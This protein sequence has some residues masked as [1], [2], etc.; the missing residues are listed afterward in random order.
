MRR[1]KGAKFNQIYKTA[2]DKIYSRAPLG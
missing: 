2:A 1:D